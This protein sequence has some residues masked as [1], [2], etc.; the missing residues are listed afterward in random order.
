MGSKAD[1]TILRDLA[2]RC[3][4]A[5]ASQDRE[6]IKRQWRRLH[7]CDME[8]PMIYIW[9]ILFT[10]ELEEITNLKCTDPFFREKEK[11]L[12]VELYHHYTGDDYLIEPFIKLRASYAGLQHGSWGVRFQRELFEGRRPVDGGAAQVYS[13][14]PLKSLDDL[15]EIRPVE[16]CID[17]ARTAERRSKL[18]DA[19][20]DIM[21][22]HVSR[23][24]VYFR[25]FFAPTVTNMRG[26][27]QIM[28]DMCENPAGL[29]QLLG[30]MQKAVIAAHEKGEQLGDLSSADQHIQS[31]PYSNY[32]VDPGPN[33]P[34]THKDLWCFVQ[35]QEF[36][37]ISPQMHKEFALDY[38]KPIMEMFAASAYGC[39]EDLTHKIDILREVKNLRQISVTPAADLERCA[40]QIG[41]D[42]VISWRPNPTDQVCATFDRERVRRL[43]AEGRD[44][45]EK[46]GCHYEINLKDV[47]TVQGERERLREWVRIVRSVID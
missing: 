3:R 29:H 4:D 41:S 44:V 42:Y 30:K 20:G 23:A 8:R 21:P 24:P 38:Q 16:H 28:M 43:I 27:A 7:D 25:E 18:E 2:K 12:R 1:I 45:L 39:C 37:G 19:V 17:E 46:H 40:E 26:L 47:L 22:V 33:T 31:C 11:E 14:P 13:A 15:S 32:T 5:A 35:S 34:A 36:T 6:R 10:D 9:V